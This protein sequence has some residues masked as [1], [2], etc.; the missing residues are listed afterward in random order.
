MPTQKIWDSGLGLSTWLAKL[1]I[2][3][4][5]ESPDK[6]PLFD[7]LMGQ[8]LCAIELGMQTALVTLIDTHSKCSIQALGLG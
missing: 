8:E 1:L 5:I 3:N 2:R 4:S 6:H 7:L